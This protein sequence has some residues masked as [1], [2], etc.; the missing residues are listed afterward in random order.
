MTIVF[1][2]SPEFAVPCLDGL[3][4]DGERVA[5]VVTQPD[6]PAGRGR[7]YAPTAVKAAALDRGLAVLTQDRGPRERERVAAAIA[8]AAPDVVVVVAFGHILREPLLS[9]PRLGCVNVH[10]SLLPR[11]RGVSPVQHA[12][13]HG[14]LWTGVT[15]LRM[16]EGV[17]TGPV[18]AVEA[19]PIDPRET[20]GQLLARLGELGAALL[21]RTLP[22]LAAGRVAPRPQ[23]DAG[24]VYA[25]KVTK[26]LSPVRWDRDAVTVHNQIRALAP[27]PGTTSFLDGKPVKIGRA[28][29]VGL[30]SG[31]APVGTVLAV[32]DRGVIVACGEG[33]IRLLEL[34][35]PGRRLLPVGEFLRGCPVEPG[36][37]FRS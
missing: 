16:D 12:I 21:R 5:L 26:G 9:L 8:E 25:P 11:W 2:G 15:L 30:C 20:G 29:P 17:D 37:V 6:R 3:L 34:Q 36:Q 22:D 1:M 27:A 35:V 10:F 19:T 13:L 14:D 7:R 23:G 33:Q 24:A 31:A 4:D 28:E 18:L 32:S